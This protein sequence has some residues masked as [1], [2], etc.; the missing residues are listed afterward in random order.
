MNTCG[1]CNK[2][3]L[4]KN[5]LTRHLLSCKIKKQKEN[6]KKNDPNIISCEF[7]N[8]VLSTQIT[9]KRHLSKCKFMEK[10]QLNIS[11]NNYLKYQNKILYDENITL[12]ERINSLQEKVKCLSEQNDKL[13]EQM[14]QLANKPT[15]KQIVKKQINLINNLAPYDISEQLVKQI[16]EQEYTQDDFKRGPNGLASFVATKIATNQAG[17]KKI[18]CTDYARRRFK[19]LND[20]GS[21]VIDDIGAIHLCKTITKP[22]KRV[23]STTYDKIKE[24]LVDEV[25]IDVARTIYMS[26]TTRLG[27]PEFVSDLAKRLLN[28]VECKDDEEED[29]D[30]DE[31]IYT[32]Y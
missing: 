1:F 11:E 30:S 31:I 21:D 14:F 8:K 7:C 19:H 29:L 17:K 10:E 6:E 4:N 23:I 25:D 28:P 16:A 15:N 32:E 2:T 13:H 3:L 27:H 26:N 24:D 18:V 5:N 20:K 12:K 9:L 22:M